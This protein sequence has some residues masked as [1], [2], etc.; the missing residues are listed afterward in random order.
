MARSKGIASSRSK[1]GASMGPASLLP[2]CISR[3]TKTGGVRLQVHVKPNAKLSAITDVSN[4]AVGVALAAPPRDGEANEELLS[5]MTQVLVVKK[6]QMELV[7]GSK[8]RDKVLLVYDLPPE[9]ALD[10]LKKQLPSAD[11]NT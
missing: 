11:D 4:E 8:S 10:K 5:F 6:K 9:E 7:S 2:A 3:C 1:E